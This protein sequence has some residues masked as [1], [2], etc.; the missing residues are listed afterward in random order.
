MKDY[1]A[2]LETHTC[3]SILD[4]LSRPADYVDRM[5][6]QGVHG[7]A[8]TDHGSLLMAVEMA[9]KCR[10]AG[11]D[12]IIGSEVYVE[13]GD[14]YSHLVL[15]VCDSLGWKNLLRLHYLASTN[16]G[17]ARRPVLKWEWIEDH[18]DG[19]WA[20]SNCIGSYVA[21]PLFATKMGIPDTPS[22]QEAMQYLSPSWREECGRRVAQ[23]KSIFGKRLSLGCAIHGMGAQL[24]Q[25]KLFRD[26]SKTYNVPLIAVSDAHYAHPEDAFAHEVLVTIGNK[27]SL[28]ERREMKSAG[29]RVYWSNNRNYHLATRQEMERRGYTKRELDNI[30]LVCEA[31]Q[32]RLEP[33][34][35]RV[36][37]IPGYSIDRMAQQ[38]KRSL[39][40]YLRSIEHVIDN[41][42]DYWDRMER[43]L[44][45]AEQHGIGP[46]IWLCAEAVKRLRKAG[47]YISA[48]GSAAGSLLAFAL[49]I[50]QVDPIAN[51]LYWERFFNP[52]RMQLP[53]IDIDVD[54]V[55]RQYAIQIVKDWIG[56]DLVAHLSTVGTFGLK[57]ALRDVIKAMSPPKMSDKWSKIVSQCVPESTNVDSL[58]SVLENIP[59]GRKMLKE[60]PK[61]TD[62]VSQLLGVIRFKGKHA[63]GLVIGHDDLRHLVPTIHSDGG[64]L[65]DVDLHAVEFFGLVK[66]DLLGLKQL[67]AV[68]HVSNVLEQ[69]DASEDTQA[70]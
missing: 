7:L 55:N 8:I 43:E 49:D 4:G 19:L 53:D 51:N 57:A 63:A 37:I 42:D 21:R 26:L 14:R 12:C 18:A 33:A 16:L 46:Y 50:T 5:V 34:A 67:S 64:L 40:E 27:S 70:A 1:W 28:A 38:A 44:R 45:D 9:E 61:L 15:Y 13:D 22:E 48:R 59:E 30:R 39:R 66:M 69:C 60:C 31:C 3:G 6:S 56:V 10:D 62:V 65:V 47:I 58:Q 2:N 25:L 17:Y 23:L 36:P 32:F 20:S 29:K 54:G 11:L 24:V 52:D 68:R 41:E 35:P